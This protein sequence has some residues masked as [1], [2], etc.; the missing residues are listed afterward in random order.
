MLTISSSDIVKKLSY[1]TKPEEI[2]FVEDANQ[3]VIRSVV[4]PYNI[5]EMIREK[6]EDELYLAANSSAL[7]QEAYDG[8]LEM[9]DV[10]DEL[11]WCR[12][13]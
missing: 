7:S 4:M 12:T 1:V 10:I 8:F 11:Q 5:Y 3:H 6:I 13:L 2:I 9:E